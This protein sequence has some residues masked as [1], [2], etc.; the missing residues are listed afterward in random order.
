MPEVH[1]AIQRDLDSLKK[2]ANRNLMQFNKEKCRVL[3]LRMNNP[4][5]QYGLGLP[6]LE[7]S[8]AEKNLGVQNLHAKMISLQAK[9]KEPRREIVEFP[10]QRF[11]KTIWMWSWAPA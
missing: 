9:K 4:K 6:Q 8:L 1:G 11:S 3:N 10:S 2:W 5:H 7:S